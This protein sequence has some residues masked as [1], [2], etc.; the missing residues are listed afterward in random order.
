MAF[1]FGLNHCTQQRLLDV[2]SQ[3]THSIILCHQ[4]RKGGVPLNTQVLL[5]AGKFT[6]VKADSDHFSLPHLHGGGR[7]QPFLLTGLSASWDT[8]S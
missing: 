8:G 6:Q 7:G 2:P 5:A 3:E 4:F 1:G